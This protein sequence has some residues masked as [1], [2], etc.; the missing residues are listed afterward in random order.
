STSKTPSYTKS[1]SWQHHPLLHK[2]INQ[3]IKNKTFDK[4][5]KEYS[6]S[7]FPETKNIFSLFEDGL[8]WNAE[9]IDRRG[10]EIAMRSPDIWPLSI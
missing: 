8:Y 4:K 3:S 9:I 1:V 10:Q 7:I 5:A 2:Q 6:D